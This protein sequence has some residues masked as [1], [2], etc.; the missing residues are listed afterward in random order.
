M[1]GLFSVGLY[2]LHGFEVFMTSFWLAIHLSTVNRV[3][4][5]EYVVAQ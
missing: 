4:M 5:K 2:K 1:D 3:Y